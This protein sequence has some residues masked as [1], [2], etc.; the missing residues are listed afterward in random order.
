ME[1]YTPLNKTYELIRN[2][3]YLT[4]KRILG[5]VKYPDIIRVYLLGFH[6]VACKSLIVFIKFLC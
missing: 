1:Q 6:M 5:N 2:V 3:R 4:L